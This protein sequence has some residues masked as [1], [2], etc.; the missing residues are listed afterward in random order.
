[1]VTVSF[2]M[3]RILFAAGG[4]G[5]HVFPAIA[6]ADEVVRLYPSAQVMFAGSPER[7]EWTAV[8]KAGYVKGRS[9]S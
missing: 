9:A 4:T 8:P 1:M 2:H 5:G 7:L 6:I 3:P